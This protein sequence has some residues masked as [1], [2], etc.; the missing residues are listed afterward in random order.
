MT[1]TCV[2]DSTLLTYVWTIENSSA[3]RCSPPVRSPDFIFKSLE[4][5]KWSLRIVANKEDICFFLKREKGDNGL[6]EIDISFEID[7]L[8]SDGSPTIEKRGKMPFKRRDYF[9]FDGFAKISEV[10]MDRREAFLPKDTLTV[11]CRMWKTDTKI[12]AHDVCFAKTRLEADRQ[13]FVWTVRQ[14]SKLQLKEK[15]SYYLKPATKGAPELYLTL[16]LNEKDGEE[17][18]H[19]KVDRGVVT[20]NFFIAG[21]ISLLNIEGKTVHSQ[22]IQAWLSVPKKSFYELENFFTK[23]KL[24]E[25]KAS[26]LPNDVLCLRCLFEIGIGVNSSLIEYISSE[27]SSPVVSYTNTNL[28]SCCPLQEDLKY[29]YEDG[30]L[31]D[32][33]LQAGF[34]CFVVHKNILAARS[35][36]FKALFEKESKE[37]A[38]GCINITK[39]DPDILR[40]ILLYIYTD[41]VEYLQWET[42]F[43]LF[44]GADMYGL[45]D[46]KEHCSSFLKANLTSTTAC[47]ALVLA[48]MHHDVK[49]K[50]TVRGF[51]LKH[52]EEIFNSDAWSSL[53][54]KNLKLAMEVMEYVYLKKLNK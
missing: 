17:C 45:Q 52:D 51:I 9:K 7:L 1:S 5:T 37:M 21:E 54:S 43:N 35:P 16:S 3:L 48:E 26:L 28:F 41:S 32:I 29:L 6:D 33:S 10:F 2:N 34:N 24:M 38:S 47:D 46:L 4:N 30:Y 39:L 13:S 20:R 25:D 53:K 11:Q 44:K 14:F 49:L 22:E 27:K 36:V 19:I 42:A 8:T 31:S 23:S 15:M 12:S 50:E 18:I 40:R